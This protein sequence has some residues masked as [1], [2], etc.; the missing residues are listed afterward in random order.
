M[1]N[2][3]RL[4]GLEDLIIV[5]IGAFIFL[6]LQYYFIK[7]AVRDGAVE[8]RYKWQE[9]QKRKAERAEEKI[10][11]KDDAEQSP[12]GLINK[13]KAWIEKKSEIR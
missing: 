1:F 13:L 4:F 10:L 7:A 11:K 9:K 6:A 8:A 12:K 3:N 5:S 2:I